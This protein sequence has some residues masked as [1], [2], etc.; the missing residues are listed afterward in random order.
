MY[1]I[2]YGELKAVNYNRK[3][4]ESEEKQILS[5]DSQIDENKKIV[6]Q[7][8]VKSLDIL[9]ESKSGKMSN[10]RPIFTQMIKDIKDGKYDSIVCW[11]LDRLA[12]NMIDGGVVM[13]MLQRGTIKC[14]IT[15]SKIYHSSENTLLLSVEFGSAN[16]FVRDLSVNVKRGQTKKASIGLPHGVATLGFLNDRAGEKGNKKWLVDEDRLWKIQKLFEMFLTGNYSA[17]R[18]YEY[19]I[20]ELK[21]TTVKRK[22]TGGNNIALSRIYDIFKDPVYAGYFFYDEQRYELDKNLPRI[23]SEAEYEKVKSL[24]SR[25][26]IPKTQHHKPVYSGYISSPLGEY[27]GGDIKKQLICDCKFKFAYSKRE[28]CPK[29]LVEISKLSN[30]KFLEYRKYINIKRKK[31]KILDRTIKVKSIE[32][33]SIDSQLSN[34]IEQSLFF[35][36]EVLGWAKKYIHELENIEMR[37]KILF[38]RNKESRK[39][40]LS[41]KK[42]KMRSRLYENQITNSEYGEDLIKLEKEYSDTKEEIGDAKINWIDKLDKIIS[43]SKIARDTILNGTYNEKRQLLSDF[44]PNLVWDEEKLLINNNYLINKIIVAIKVSNQEFAKYEPNLSFDIQ[45]LNEKTPL[46]RDDFSI[47][48]RE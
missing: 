29:C 37:N 30:P 48:L 20:N 11:K 34:H 13:D 7:L 32:E 3:S 42:S 24:L 41:D 28:T 47:M 19:A 40:E 36:D 38:E 21:L 18:L 12:R 9:R 16:Q 5:I 31:A 46:K 1:E 22:R 4:S 44:S 23:I 43:V 6:S 17:S 8:G 25:K 39:I 14:I 2:N 35:A 15:P 27:I 45:G 10:K 26:N 33:S